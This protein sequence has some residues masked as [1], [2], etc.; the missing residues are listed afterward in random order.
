[1][2][3][4][5]INVTEDYLKFL[6]GLLNKRTNVIK[7]NLAKKEVVV[8]NFN[9]LNLIEKS[10]LEIKMYFGCGKIVIFSI[11][12]DSDVVND[13]IES[14]LKLLRNKDVYIKQ[15]I[16]NEK[17][18]FTIKNK[19]VSFQNDNIISV[20]NLNNV[21]IGSQKQIDDT[22]S[23]QITQNG[24]LMIDIPCEKKE[25]IVNLINFLI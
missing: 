18:S 7:I 6:S 1:M 16:L 3:P 24:K 22:W 10:D 19:M 11:E 13:F 25:E 23:F 2:E 8:L 21:N 9:F 12:E 14:V 15:M 17:T 5:T 4:L 20:F